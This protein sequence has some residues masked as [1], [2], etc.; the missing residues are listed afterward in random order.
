MGCNFAMEFSYKAACKS[1]GFKPESIQDLSAIGA[2]LKNFKHEEYSGAFR[3]F[4]F[5]VALATN[6][7]LPIKVINIYLPILVF[8]N[9]NCSNNN[10]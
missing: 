7:T 8:L 5:L 10:I 1:R 9:L 6:E 2:F 4:N 3:D